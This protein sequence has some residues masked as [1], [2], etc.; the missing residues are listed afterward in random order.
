MEECETHSLVSEQGPLG[1]SCEHGDEPSC[2]IKCTE[3]SDQMS[4]YDLVKK[5]LPHVDTCLIKELSL[6]LLGHP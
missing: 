5:T 1:G 6:L 2:F 4:N 3:F